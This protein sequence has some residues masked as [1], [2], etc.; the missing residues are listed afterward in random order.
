MR[1]VENVLSIK[2]AHY[3]DKKGIPKFKRCVGNGD[4][5]KRRGSDFIGTGLL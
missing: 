2:K 1:G 5:K 3:S 4:F